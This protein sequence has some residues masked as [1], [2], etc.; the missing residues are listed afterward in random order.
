[1]KTLHAALGVLVAS[2]GLISTLAAAPAGVWRGSIAVPGNP[3]DIKI[4]LKEE[5]SKWS[6]TIDIPAQ[7]IKAWT[8]KDVSVKGSEIRFAMPNVPGDPT[9]DGQLAKDAK[10]I[11]GDFSQ[12]GGTMKF[13]LRPSAPGEADPRPDSSQNAKAGLGL[14]GYWS[15]KLQMAGTS[16]RLGMN[17]K[18]T[19]QGRVSGTLD[20]PDQNTMDIPIE[21]ITLENGQLAVELPALKARFEGK[22]T[23]DKIAGEWQQLGNSLPLILTRQDKAPAA[24]K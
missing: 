6:G 5:N 19:P 24:T 2:L 17:I 23:K 11:T 9:F 21:K 4:T 14:E 16:L 15:G 20:S 1:M 13:S 7:G 18:K 3:L 10:S 22:L 8:L 12:S